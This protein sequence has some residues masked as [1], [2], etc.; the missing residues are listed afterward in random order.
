MRNAAHRDIS[1]E[2]SASLKQGWMVVLRS[3]D[4][5]IRSS[6]GIFLGAATPPSPK[7]VPQLLQDEDAILHAIQTDDF[8]ANVQHSLDQEDQ[9]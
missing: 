1:S 2:P 7:F 4:I 5:I 6:I 8:E 3:I 9:E